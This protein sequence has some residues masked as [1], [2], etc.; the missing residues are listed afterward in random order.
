MPKSLNLT[1]ESPKSS[2][3]DL[4]ASSYTRLQLFALTAITTCIS[5]LHH[6]LRHLQPLL[7]MSNYTLD[8][9]QEQ[10]FD[11]LAL[12]FAWMPW[13][14]AFKFGVQ[15]A[16][17]N[18]ILLT[19][20]LLAGMAFMTNGGVINASEK[21]LFA[22]CFLTK[23][24]I[25]GVQSFVIFYIL[26]K[27][28]PLLRGKALAIVCTMSMALSSFMP[29]MLQRPT[30]HTYSLQLMMIGLSLIAFLSST[31]LTN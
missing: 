23:V 9:Y 29:I 21:V 17:S 26:L 27:I 31:L 19:T 13:I 25:Y 11:G 28:E 16:I 12:A 8:I 14:F 22:G 4:L 10:Y 7:F 30:L 5:C 6:I 3:V 18:T 24:G 15:R 2:W 1:Q 20:L